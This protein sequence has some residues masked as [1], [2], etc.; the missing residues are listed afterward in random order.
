MI[1]L[2]VNAITKPG[3]QNLVQNTTAQVSIETGLK[4]AGRPAF[5]LADKNVDK[6]TRKYSAVK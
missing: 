2:F 5:T 4:A 6:E 1:N 3:F